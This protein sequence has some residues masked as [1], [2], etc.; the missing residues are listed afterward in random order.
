[1]AEGR[2]VPDIEIPLRS[3]EVVCYPSPGEF[4]AV[5]EVNA[6]TLSAGSLRIG[7]ASLGEVRRQTRRWVLNAA[8]TYSQRLGF[9][10]A[11]PRDDALLLVT[12]HQPALFHPG[13][14]IK[15]LL[16]NR[17]A[18]EGVGGLSLAVDSDTIE[19]IGV[20]VPTVS[21]GLQRTHETLLRADPDVPYEAH[22]RPSEAVWRTFLDRVGAHLQTLGD[23]SVAGVFGEFVTR[24]QGLDESMDLGT[25]M[26]AV[27]RRHEGARPYLELPVSALTTSPA[28]RAFFLHLVRDAARFADC[29][30]RHLDLYRGR[31]NIRTP[32]QPFPNLAVTADRVE[33]PFWILHEG[34][35]KPCFIQPHPEGW[36]LYAGEMTVGLI[37]RMGAIAPDGLAIRPRALTLTAFTRL[38]VADLF[39]HG[40]GGGRYDRVTDGVIREYFGVEPPRY[41]V[42]TATLH[43]PLGAF[44]TDAE[45]QALQRQILEMRHNPERVLPS[46]SAEER[47][48]IEEKWR[49]IAALDGGAMSRRER[50]QAT[51]QIRE[52]NDRLAQALNHDRAVAEQRLADLASGTGA[53]AAATH[54][55]YPFCFFP[56]SA[57]DE[58]ISSILGSR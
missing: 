4:H 48:L 45:R 11:T 38:C 25:F 37:S 12:G 47:V 29:Y 52:I 18:G 3:G 20:D 39:V 41:A 16:V 14:W 49:L 54:R 35:R 32:A 15:Q 6:R 22:A 51:Q 36:Q 42:V 23:S 19:E 21:D 10:T 58:L 26:T 43:L 55:G 1:M 5:A 46:P 56:P 2:T 33:V 24:A 50:R 28:F 27:R 13:I 40:V 30:N 57:V 34:R 17:M 7:E 44:K 9:W 31:S 53:V 8:T